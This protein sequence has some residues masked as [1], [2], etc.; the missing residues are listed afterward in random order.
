VAAVEARVDAGVV[1]VVEA[2]FD[3][4]TNVVDAKPLQSSPVAVDVVEQRTGFDVADV[5]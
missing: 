5:V 2:A 3:D 4:A 1:G